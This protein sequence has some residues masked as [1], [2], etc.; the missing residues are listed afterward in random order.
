MLQSNCRFYDEA[1]YGDS[2]SKAIVFVLLQAIALAAPVPEQ[3]TKQLMSQYTEETT[4]L[5]GKSS[6]Q[7]GYRVE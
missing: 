1:G 4:C 2:M 3:E 7:P 6:E 5:F